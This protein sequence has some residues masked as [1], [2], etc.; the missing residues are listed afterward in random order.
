MFSNQLGI[1][2]LL[3]LQ[4]GHYC[5]SQS[6]QEK[7]SQTFLENLSK[8]LGRVTQSTTCGIRNIDPEDPRTEAPWNAVIFTKY[9]AKNG[10]ISYGF[11]GSGVVIGANMILVISNGAYGAGTKESNYSFYS[12][13]PVERFIAVVG[14]KSI[15][16]DDSDQH[17][18]ISEINYIVP[19]IGK[20]EVSDEFH[21]VIY[22]LKTVLKP[23]NYVREICFLKL[24]HLNSRDYL[25][26]FRD[27]F[28]FQITGFA[29]RANLNTN[30]SPLT[31]DITLESQSLCD[32]AYPFYHGGNFA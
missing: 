14:L 28:N 32:S 3:I 18:Q 8:S 4:F 24:Q 12:I 23:T 9:Q 31:R 2:L 5:Y 15:R 17:T 27:S 22:H 25:Q 1:L 19:Y 13:P 10:T 16:F 6:G 7:E 29:L 11:F 20:G 21:F 26:K 30:Y